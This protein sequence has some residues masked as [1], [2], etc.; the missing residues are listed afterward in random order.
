MRW[1]AISHAFE[2][3]ALLKNMPRNQRR[4]VARKWSWPIRTRPLKDRHVLAAAV[5]ARVDLLVTANV[6]DFPESATAP[7]G[8]KVAPPDDFL[9]DLLGFDEKLVLEV[10]DDMTLQKTRPPMTHLEML[11]RIA[12]SAPNFAAAALMVL[13]S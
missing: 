4:I 8:I 2:L 9:V 5:R 3:K 13:E 11:R 7:Y 1:N 6:K 10:I 12:K